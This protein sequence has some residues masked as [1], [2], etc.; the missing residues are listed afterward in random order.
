MFWLFV[1]YGFEEKLQD[2]DVLLNFNSIEFDPFK[3][4]K[5]IDFFDT[6]TI[7]QVVA[8][9]EGMRCF[10]V[11]LASFFVSWKKISKFK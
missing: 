8:T 7:I 6:I 11:F 4:R 10:T 2:K 3:N 9:T 1:R 5:N